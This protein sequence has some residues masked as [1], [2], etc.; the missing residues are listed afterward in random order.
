[1]FGHKPFLILAD[2][3]TRRGIAV[4]RADDRGVGGSKGDA[5]QATSEDFA[6]DALAGVEYLKTRRQIDP[7][8]I[9]LIGHSEGGIIAPLANQ[10]SPFAFMVLMAGTA[11]NGREVLL[12]QIALIAKADGA[13]ETEIAE[14]V[15]SQKQAYTLIGR[16]DGEKE[17][18]KMIADQVRASLA[19]MA[20]EQRRAVTDP[21]VYV[22]SATAAQMAVLHSP[23]FRHFLDYDPAPALEMV[24]CPV[25]AL[26]GERDTQVSPKQNMPAMEKAF[27]KG[28][29]RDVTF[30]VFPE[31][32]HLFQKART[33]SPSEYAS[34]EKAFIPGFL[35]TISSWILEKTH[36]ENK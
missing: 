22:Q 13:G 31:A 14:A 6:D 26:F 4:L 5:A 34:L 10:K 27:Q 9:G 29:N 15:A 35:D 17:I 30:K 25:L 16:P 2:Y 33:G 1:M 28:G 23:W 7:K 21:G 36:G 18:E 12:E 24:K 19:K 32:N 20:P 3:L 11:V 8:Q